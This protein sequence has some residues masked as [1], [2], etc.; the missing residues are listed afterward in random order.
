MLFNTSYPYYYISSTN[1]ISGISSSSS[2]FFVVVYSKTTA[3][4]YQNTSK[5]RLKKNSSLNIDLITNRRQIVNVWYNINHMCSYFFCCWRIYLE[6]SLSYYFKISKYTYTKGKTTSSLFWKHQRKKE[7]NID[8]T[9][10]KKNNNNIQIHTPVFTLCYFFFNVRF[11]YKEEWERMIY[12][13]V[14]I[15]KLMSKRRRNVSYFLLV[16]RWI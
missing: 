7:E 16:N 13:Y 10:K 4:V 9:L 5:Y 1:R 14:T 6:S 15:Q 12:I 11:K 8:I 3:S 2:F